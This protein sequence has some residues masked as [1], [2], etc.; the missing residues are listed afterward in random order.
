MQ[1]KFILIVHTPIYIFDTLESTMNEIKKNKYNSYK[2]VVV[3]AQRQT[4]GRGRR[5]NTWISDKGNLYLS[6]RLKQ[7]IKKNHHLLTYMFS[8]VLYDAIKKIYS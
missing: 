3:L 7:K 6:I 5:N 4:N 2:E 8:I 1:K